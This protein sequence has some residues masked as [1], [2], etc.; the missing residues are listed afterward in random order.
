VQFEVRA[1]PG[2]VEFALH[3]ADGAGFILRL[4]ALEKTEKNAAIVGAC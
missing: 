1:F 3:P 2:G 4:H